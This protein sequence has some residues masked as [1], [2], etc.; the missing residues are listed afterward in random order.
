MSNENQDPYIWTIFNDMFWLTMAGI[1]A[2]V[3]GVCVNGII[4]SHCKQVSFCYGMFKCERDLE[5]VDANDETV[6]TPPPPVLPP[7]RN[8]A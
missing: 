5:A 2:G 4:K 6:T 1:L 7:A 8:R 3:F